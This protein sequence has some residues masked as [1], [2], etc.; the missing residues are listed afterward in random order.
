MGPIRPIF[1]LMGSRDYDKH[2]K[3]AAERSR[4]KA[5]D[6]VDIGDVPKCKA[7]KRRSRCK[8][9]LR[10]FCVTYFADKFYLGFGPDHERLIK[11]LER[12]VLKGELRALAMPRGS[13]KTTLCEIA[14]LWAMLY[15]HRRFVVII[16]ADKEHAEGMLATIKIALEENVLLERDFPEVCYPIEQLEGSPSRCGKQTCKGV[17]T[18][19]K[20]ADDCVVFPTI[21]GSKCSGSVIKCRG[22]LG[23]IRGMKH[24]LA[25]GEDIRPDLVIIDDPQT[26]ES[27]ASPPQCRKRLKVLCGAILGLAGPG[28]KRI[29]GMMP[30]TV[31]E[32]GDLADQILDRDLYPQWRGERVAFVQKWPPR[33]D[34]WEKYMELRREDLKFDRGGDS[35][36]KFYI[37]NRKAMDAGFSVYW[38]DRVD[39]GEISAQQHFFNH[40]V[41][42][43]PEKAA[44]EY[45]ND[46][47][48]PELV[49]HSSEFDWWIT[50]SAI[51]KKC[52]GY[53][54]RLVPDE[55]S[56]I[57]GMI[58]VHENVLYWGLA[59]WSESFSGWVIDYGAWPEQRDRY[60]AK[61]ATTTITLGHKYRK[62][63]ASG[64]EALITQGLA[65]LTDHI[66]GRT[67]TRED[68]TE[69]HV[70]R[71]LVD[72]N[73]GP[74]ADTVYDFCHRSEYRSILM[75]SHGQGITAGR[76]RIDAVPQ[77]PGEIV[78]HNW[79]M[80][81]MRRSKRKIRYINFDAN[82]WLVFAFRRLASPRGAV[83]CL[84]LPGGDPTD[85]QLLADHLK[86][87]TPAKT[88][89]PYGDRVE[90]SDP[91][92]GQDNH[93]SDILVGLCV[94]ASQQGC[95]LPGVAMEGRGG[96]RT[97]CKGRRRLSSMQ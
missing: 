70:D 8:N 26:E 52:S 66:L 33:M 44:S 4:K 64:T 13:G 71:C 74:E 22:L 50:G 82:A 72:A 58:D 65:D 60:F 93:F 10:A 46:P 3:K 7:P 38:V 36:T 35:A 28:K 43:G 68:G 31:L 30:C 56:K 23:R 77:R 48:C 94:G 69:Q 55:A 95:Q 78:G 14:A 61:N 54:Y 29:A 25:S 41:D 5:A 90:W 19:M 37:R 12:A 45:Q 76:Q 53:E 17:R 32:P 15:G 89:G 1:S 57:T 11:Q 16:G 47:N 21:K 62:I 6:G 86:S 97:K 81:A 39:E 92:P 85:H 84:E 75:P 27:A 40:V 9:S 63:A 2:R 91:P 96:R 18:R 49:K 24:S 34:L 20:W 79:R 73:Y 51:C 80:P 83:G 42:V 88:S 87:Q 59:A 67:Y